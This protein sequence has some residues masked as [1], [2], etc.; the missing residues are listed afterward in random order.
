MHVFYLHGFASSA[1]SKKAAYLADRCREHG[2]RLRCP[3]FNEPDF[4]TLTLTRML[5]QIDAE[6]ATLDAQPV[7]LI[8]SSLGGVV[9][10]H[11]AARRPDRVARL[12]LMAGAVRAD[13]HVWPERVAQWRDRRMLDVFTT[14]GGRRAPPT[15]VLRD[16][17]CMMRSADVTQPILL[18]QAAR[19]RRPSSTSAAAIH[20]NVTLRLLDDDHQLIAILPTMWSEMSAFLSLT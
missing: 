11:V 14:A 13:G 19:R 7:V 17:L 2:L 20:S 16:S 12:V 8:G 9:A 1:R 4:A 15:M 6:L 10:L 18:F 5:D 3:D